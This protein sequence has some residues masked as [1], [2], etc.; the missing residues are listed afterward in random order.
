MPKKIILFFLIALIAVPILLASPFRQSYNILS[1]LHDTLDI[2]E[3]Y[4]IAPRDTKELMYKAVEGMVSS[5]DPYSAF[6]KPEEFTMLKE[7]VTSEYAG[8]G[9]TIAFRDSEVW[10]VGVSD[11]SPA[12]RGGVMTKDQLLAIDGKEVARL[13]ENDV[14]RML[15]GEPDTKVLIRLLRNE[16]LLTLALT[17]ALVPIEHV[18]DPLMLTETIGY[19]RIVDFAERT[20]DELIEA[21]LN[22][23]NE[24]MTHCVLDLRFNRGGVLESSVEVCELFVTPGTFVVRVRGKSPKEH[25]VYYADAI[26]PFS[27]IAL[28]LLINKSTASGAEIVADVL[29]RHAGAL[30]VG[31]RSMGKGSVQQII[32]LLDGS[33]VKLTTAE[34]FT[35]DDTK[36]D[37]L[38]VMPTVE[39][40]HENVFA[41]SKEAVMESIDNEDMRRQLMLHDTQVQAA[42][43]LWEI[44][45]VKDEAV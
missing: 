21:L 39:V 30:L 41:Q 16:Q 17:R 40:T 31:Q 23:I 8:L 24:G 9:I 38:G 14:V 27:D 32:P 44:S 42:L 34:Y 36:I 29:K 1:L 18:V 10:I 15:R 45:T 22:L 43:S 2:I 26:P 37:G 28:I 4:Y 12:A 33:A 35:E 3:A 20:A 5:L 7:D 25:T 13:G 6:L 11:R 19:I